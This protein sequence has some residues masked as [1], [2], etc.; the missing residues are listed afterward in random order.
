MR[1][2]GAALDDADRLSEEALGGPSFSVGDRR[3]EQLPIN[4][5]CLPWAPS[6]GAERS[7]VRPSR[8]EGVAT[9]SLATCA[10]SDSICL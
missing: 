5:H 3:S 2:R 4:R 8:G 7:G 1:V 6:S 10:H 9:R